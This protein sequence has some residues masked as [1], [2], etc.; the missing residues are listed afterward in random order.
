MILHQGV[1][2]SRV[3]P[4]HT[5]SGNPLEVAGHPTGRLWYAC[6][7]DAAFGIPFLRS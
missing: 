1:L 6:V 5:L 2:T 3:N 7:F 4:P